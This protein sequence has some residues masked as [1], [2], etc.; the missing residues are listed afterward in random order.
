MHDYP[1]DSCAASHTAFFL[2]QLNNVVWLSAMVAALLLLWKKL[3]SSKLN[4]WI[5]RDQERALVD[6][7]RTMD[8]CQ[9]HQFNDQI[10]CY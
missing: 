3:T 4:T 6:V 9:V 2:A 1:A 10:I 7:I 8:L 5:S